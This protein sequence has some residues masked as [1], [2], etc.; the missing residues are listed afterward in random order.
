MFPGSKVCGPSETGVV[1]KIMGPE[2]AQLWKPW[3]GSGPSVAGNGPDAAGLQVV[4]TG[5]PPAERTAYAG[6]GRHFV[7]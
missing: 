3:P 4:G 7:Q 2:A 5:T 1:G 6:S